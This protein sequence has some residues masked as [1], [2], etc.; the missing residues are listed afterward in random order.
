MP[1]KTVTVQNHPYSSIQQQHAGRDQ[2]QPLKLNNITISETE[3]YLSAFERPFSRRIW[4]NWMP[5]VFFLQLFQ[6]KTIGDKWHRFFMGQM[7]FLL[8]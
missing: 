5:S 7:S 6:K 8:P 1:K 2:L 4:V 3:Y